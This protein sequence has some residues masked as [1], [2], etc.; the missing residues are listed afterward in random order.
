MGNYLQS[1]RLERVDRRY[2]GWHHSIIIVTLHNSHLSGGCLGLALVTVVTLV[3]SNRT[4]AGCSLVQAPRTTA[5]A[6]VTTENR[7]TIS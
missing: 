1:V 2:V 4:I 5:I 6:T 3:G 7:A